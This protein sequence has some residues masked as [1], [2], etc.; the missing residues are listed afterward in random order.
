MAAENKKGCFRR[1]L[2]CGCFALVAVVVVLVVAGI[3]CR[4]RYLDWET[5]SA[6][7]LEGFEMSTEEYDEIEA[8]LDSRLEEFRESEVQ[9]EMIYLDCDTVNVLF[10]EVV[11]ENWENLGVEKVGVVCN[12]RSLDVYANYQ[13][14]VWVLIKVWQ[15]ADGDVDFVVYDVMVGLFSLGT[16]SFGY[17]TDQFTEGVQDALELITSGSFSGRKIEE[18]YIE[19]EGVRVIGVVEE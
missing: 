1:I 6:E 15:R 19:E 7:M 2:S 3:Y 8:D 12:E 11:Y 4:K 18:I 13:G 5:E 16:L 14:S 9:R 17:V 10:K